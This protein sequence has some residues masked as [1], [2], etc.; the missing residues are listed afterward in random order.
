MQ[1]PLA[2]FSNYTYPHFRDLGN[3]SGAPIAWFVSHCNAH[4]GRWG[5]IALG[6][7]LH[8]L[9]SRDKYIQWLQRWIG[10]DVYGKCG[11]KQSYLNIKSYF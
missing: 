5:W 10:V 7:F 4:S 11:N 3:I 9:Y 8:L 2:D 1:A 6:Y